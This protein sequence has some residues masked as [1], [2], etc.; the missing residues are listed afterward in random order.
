MLAALLALAVACAPTVPGRSS[1][2]A[3]PPATAGPAGAATPAAPAAPDFV[4][5]T[6]AG[7]RFRLSDRQGKVVGVLFLAS[8]CASCVLEAEAWGRLQREYGPDRLEVLLVSADPGDTP[9]DLEQFRRWAQGTPER[10][11]AIDQDGRALVLPFGV[12]ALD[13]TLIFDRQG[14]LAYRDAVPSPYELLKRALE[15]LL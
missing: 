1:P 6:V 15:Q 7:E 10:H 4:I 11:W 13:T 12:H 3:G 14:R 8:W 5:E 2:G 9:A